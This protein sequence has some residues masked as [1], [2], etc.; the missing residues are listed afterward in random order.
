VWMLN[1]Q[2]QPWAIGA[3]V[4]L[5]AGTLAATWL[6]LRKRRW[7]AILAT[8]I[9]ALLLIDCMEE[10]Y[11]ELTPRQSGLEVAEKMKPHIGPGTR[12]YF[13]GHYEQTVPFY[14]GRTLQLFDYEDEFE[15]G[16]KAEARFAKR[17]LHEF[18]PEW[19]RPGDALAIMQ[20][21]VYEQLKRQGLPMAVLHADPKRVL[22]RKP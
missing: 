4:C 7:L 10:A 9:A 21:R 14:L 13:V 17:E 11:E 1:Q 15:T 22:V 3:S 18:P 6:L 8:T 12:L 5:L 16:Q 19:Q 2:M 20:P